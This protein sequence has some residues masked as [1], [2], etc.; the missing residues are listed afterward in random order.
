MSNELPGLINQFLEYM[1]IEKNCSKLTLRDYKH[2]LQV[3]NN[4][5]F[6]TLPNKK[7]EDLEIKS[8]DEYVSS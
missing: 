4:W 8:W 5:Y 6:T 1:E 2:Y 7:I 3:F